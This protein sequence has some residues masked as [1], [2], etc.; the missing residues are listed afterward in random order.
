MMHKHTNAFS[1]T[2][3]R[4]KLTI[5]AQ[6]GWPRQRTISGKNARKDFE[7][8]CSLSDSS[9]NAAIVFD[10]GV[11]VFAKRNTHQKGNNMLDRFTES[12][13][14]LHPSAHEVIASSEHKHTDTYLVR[15]NEAATKLA[16]ALAQAAYSVKV[17][18][19]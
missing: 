4:D 14:R 13:K 2:F 16:R 15:D 12:Y 11:G 6:A 5:K 10:Y 8:L 1:A 7:Y 18:A 17:I 19:L 9:F 3:N